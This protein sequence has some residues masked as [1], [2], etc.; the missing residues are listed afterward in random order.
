M[1]KLMKILLILLLLLLFFLNI[2]FCEENKN[3]NYFSSFIFGYNYYTPKLNSIRKKIKNA[4]YGNLDN[5]TGPYFSIH[6]V[7]DDMAGI[8]I[9]Y[10]K[11]NGKSEYYS[12][13]LKN[14][15]LNG[16]I[17]LSKP[18]DRLAGYVSGGAN[19]FVL[20]RNGIPGENI[21]AEYVDFP[22]GFNCLL[23]LA[24]KI[25]GSLYIG[26]EIG[27][28]WS[29]INTLGGTLYDFSDVTN[30]FYIGFLLVD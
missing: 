23:G 11:Y 5:H 12:L 25:V 26:Y 10:C 14:I 15:L 30:S 13:S 7:K 3:V 27:Y 21:D 8:M 20:E 2:S 18:G 9:G 28:T 24:Y 29:K 19:F 1:Y 16:I 17:I 6:G 4:G 22:Y